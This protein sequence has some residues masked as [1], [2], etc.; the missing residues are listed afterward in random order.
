M[1]PVTRRIA[2]RDGLVL[3]ALDW[4]GDEGRTPLLCLTGILRTAHDYDRFAERHAGKRRVVAL[5]YMGHGESARAADIAR[6]R[7]ERAVNDVLDA[8]AAL[9]LPRAVV[10]GTSFGGIMA[11]ILSVLRPTLLRGVVLNDIGPVI[12][13]RGLSQVGGFAGNDPGFP[14][15]DEAVAYLRTVMPR[16]PLADEEAWRHFAGLTYARGEDGLLHP[17]WDTRIAEAMEAGAAPPDLGPVFRGL[18]PVP[19]M[20]VWGEESE[21]LA[22]DTVRAMV[23]E[24][25]DLELVTLPGAGHAP[26]LEE[27]ELVGPVDDFLDRIP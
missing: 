12:D 16:I 14:G 19:A 13:P 9:H 10:V 3:N 26:T 23:R 7:P 15:I 6:Y 17:R 11:M 27:P 1:N 5:D 4:P 20:L 22:A 21:F 24:K 2:A 8:C 25:P 18:R